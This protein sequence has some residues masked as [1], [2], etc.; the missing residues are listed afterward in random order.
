MSDS[1]DRGLAEDLAKSLQVTTTLMQSL[2]GEIRDNATSLAVLK[3][4]LGGIEDKVNSLSH[5]IRNDNGDKSL[6]TRIALM[7][8]IIGD[9]S[10]GLDSHITGDQTQHKEFFLQ[11][12]RLNRT[13]YQD[14]KSDAEFSR[15]KTIN[16]IKLIAVILPGLTALGIML[17]KFFLG[18]E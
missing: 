5:I 18:A 6:I 4:K 12:D 14:Q 13:L 17:V 11:L 7:E 15:E 3:Q 10:K 2:L 16:I 9:L 1:N 8:K